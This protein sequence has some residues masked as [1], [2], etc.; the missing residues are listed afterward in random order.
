MITACCVSTDESH[1]M[2]CAWCSEIFTPHGVERFCGHNCRQA[3]R[4]NRRWQRTM[5][6]LRQ[7]PRRCEP[8]VLTPR[9]RFDHERWLL[10]VLD[11]RDMHVRH[12]GKVH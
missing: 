2:R 11:E 9:E 7:A 4:R 12:D 1:D 8:S 10:S 6:R 5:D 3:Q